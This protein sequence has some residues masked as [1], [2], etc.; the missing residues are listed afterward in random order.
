M[1]FSWNKFKSGARAITLISGLIVTV[2][3][4]GACRSAGESAAGVK[5]SATPTIAASP[6]PD[7]RPI[8]L[9]FG[10]SLTAGY[11]LPAD[12]A[13]P[14]LLQ[15]KI[16]AAGYRYRVSM[17]ESQGIRLLAACDVSSGRSPGP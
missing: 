7:E 10:D 5:T 9:A 17:P 6:T 11:G 14:N 3:A 1:P 13:Y 8:L 4:P 16:D 12:E 15:R 2:L